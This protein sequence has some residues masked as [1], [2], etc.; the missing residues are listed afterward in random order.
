[1]SR[2]IKDLIELGEKCC[3][4]IESLCEALEQKRE[5]LLN[6]VLDGDSAKDLGLLHGQLHDLCLSNDRARFAL[7]KQ[8][9]MLNQLKRGARDRLRAMGQRP[10][11]TF[12][13]PRQKRVKETVMCPFCGKKFNFFRRRNICDCSNIACGFCIKP[14]STFAGVELLAEVL[15][16]PSEPTHIQ[17]AIAQVDSA[18]DWL[19]PTCYRAKINSPEYQEYARAVKE[20][21]RVEIVSDP[22]RGKNPL[23][24]AGFEKAIRSKSHRNKPDALKQLKAVAAYY[25]CFIIYNLKYRD[26]T[27]EYDGYIYPLWEASGICARKP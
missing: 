23:S 1:M 7:K 24:A 21:D 11:K 13:R 20:A 3:E 19:C 14:A 5:F 12:Y 2:P 15:N 25:N 27:G 9:S 17:R 18:A 10:P 4:Q 8:E 22:N 6:S 26:F 16:N